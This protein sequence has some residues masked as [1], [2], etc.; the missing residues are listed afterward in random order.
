MDLIEL[1]EKYGDKIC[2]MG[3]IDIRLMALEDSRLLEKEIKEKITVAK[4]DGGYIY[5]SDH[6]VPNNVNFQQ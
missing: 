6:S 3:G 1:K 5:H 4:E 2:F